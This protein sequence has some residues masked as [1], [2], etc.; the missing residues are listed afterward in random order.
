MIISTLNSFNYSKL[1]PQIFAVFLNQSAYKSHS[2][3]EQHA[4]FVK[5]VESYYIKW[6]EWFFVAIENNEV[7]G[8]ICACPDSLGALETISFK[9]YHLFK[10][11]YQEYK[12]K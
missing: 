1:K 7:L 5:W 12:N 6:P 3:E 9:S 4:Y 11:Y 8:Y 10:N 2:E